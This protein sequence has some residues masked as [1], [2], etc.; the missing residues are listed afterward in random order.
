[1]ML[2]ISVASRAILSGLGFGQFIMLMTV[3]ASRLRAFRTGSINA[4]TDVSA[5]LVGDRLLCLAQTA[6]SS[7]G[8][9]ALSALTL[10]AHPMVEQML[11][12]FTLLLF[13]N[14][15]SS[16]TCASRPPSTYNAHTA[17]SCLRSTRSHGLS[18]CHTQLLD[19]AWEVAHTLRFA[20]I[21]GS[22]PGF[23]PQV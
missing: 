4:S 18:V 23:H 21:R 6:P 14:C 16:Y 9:H 3:C 2:S 15:A 13:A 11:M 19:L 22:L 1:M 10:D 12:Q 17:R 5:L 20:G 7:S 8:W